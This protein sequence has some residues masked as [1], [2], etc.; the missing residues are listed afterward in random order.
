MAILPAQND[1]L[2][3]KLRK[4]FVK[5]A[6]IPLKFLK[7]SYPETAAGHGRMTLLLS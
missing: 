4:S 3:L 5:G 7:P 2:D 1:L 6:S